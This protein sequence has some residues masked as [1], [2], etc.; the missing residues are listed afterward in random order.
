LE[1]R[2]PEERSIFLRAWEVKHTVIRERDRELFVR[3]LGPEYFDEEREGG[4]EN[5]NY[6]AQRK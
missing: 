1:L 3:V 5:G 6:T 2:N 4:F